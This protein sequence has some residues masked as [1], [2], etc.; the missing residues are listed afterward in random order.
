MSLKTKKWGKKM[1]LMTYLTLETLF[2][3]F[4]WTFI[5]RANMESFQILLLPIPVHNHF[6]QSQGRLQALFYHA[7]IP[8]AS[9]DRKTGQERKEQDSSR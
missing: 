1:S 4:F 7:K 2:G 5:I 3:T 9:V 8:A 6:S